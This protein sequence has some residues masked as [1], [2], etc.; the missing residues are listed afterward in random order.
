MKKSLAVFLSIAALALLFSTCAKKSTTS[1][2]ECISNFM[3][4]INSADRSGVYN[5]LDSNS[6][7][8]NQAKVASYWNSQFPT[9]D[10]PYTL[11]GQS[12]GNP[13][14][15]TLSSSN[16]LYNGNPIIFGMASDSDGNAVISSISLNGTS[17]FD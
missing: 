2:S 12:S 14:Y 10:M 3:S 8:Y 9:Q 13:I 1:N 7:K 4:D 17:I 6:S 15:A 16:G 11:S 5:N